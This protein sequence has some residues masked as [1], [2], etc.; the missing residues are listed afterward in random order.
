MQVVD[1]FCGLGGFSLAAHSVGW[2][3]VLFCDSREQSPYV[4]DI[5]PRHFPD[6]PL[7]DDV[8]TLTKEIVREVLPSGAESMLTAGFP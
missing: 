5:I 3:T 4:W 6:V 7:H 1:L 8:R 2:E